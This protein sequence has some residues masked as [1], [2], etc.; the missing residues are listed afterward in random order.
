[1]KLSLG[2][3]KGSIEASTIELFQKA[4]I[5][6]RRSERSYYPVCDDPELDLVLMRPQEIPRYV[7]QGV[8]DAGITGQ[9]WVEENSAKIV[10]V[11]ELRYSKS[12]RNKCRWVL[13]VPENSKFKKPHDL[14]GGRIATELVA[15]TKRYFKKLRI[16]VDVEFSWGAT[17]VKPPRLADAIVDITET[18]SSMRANRLRIIDTVMETCTVIIANRDAWK[19]KNKHDKLENMTILLQG[20]LDAENYVGLKCNVREA[21]LAAVI[22]VLPALHNP[23]ISHLYEQGW[24]AVETILPFHETKHIVPRLK[25]AGASGIVEYPVSK[26]IP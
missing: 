9:D 21:R 19:R 3:P 15:T 12:T 7:E 5:H 18:G 24:Y 1:M 11:T 14:N 2:L 22:K 6:I 8:L 26:V 16:P 4:G 10:E 13:A 17:E 20:T 25:R 23:T